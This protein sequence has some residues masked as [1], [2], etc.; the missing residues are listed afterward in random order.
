MRLECET[1]VVHCIDYRLQGYLNEWLDN[2]FPAQ[3]YDRVSIAGGVYDSD[4]LI[5]QVGLAVR[6]H[7]I[8]RVV[9]INHEDCGAYGDT[10]TIERH[11]ADLQ[12]A[13]R[14]IVQMFPDLNTESYYLHLDGTFERLGETDL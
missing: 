12:E 5:G 14:E 9:L 10:G 6:L 11:R 2:R 1:L 8:S 3:S 4:Y 13:E 7:N